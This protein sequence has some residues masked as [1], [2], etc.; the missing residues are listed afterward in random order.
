MKVEQ[1]FSEK[2]FE[3]LSKFGGRIQISLTAPFTERKLQDDQLEF[4][5]EKLRNL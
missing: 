5:I 3:K 2:D 1:L 4:M